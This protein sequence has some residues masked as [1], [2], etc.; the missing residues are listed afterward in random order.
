RADRQRAVGLG[1][2][3]LHAGETLEIHQPRRLDQVLLHVVEQVDPAGLQHAAGLLRLQRAGL[4]DAGRFGELEA[5][6][7]ALLLA[8]ASAASITS[9]VIGRRRTRA[10]VAL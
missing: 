4:G 7:Y 1:L 9:G 5:V 6:H 10:P 8:S 2:D 3:L